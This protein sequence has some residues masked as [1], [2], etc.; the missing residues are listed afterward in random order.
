MFVCVAKCCLLLTLM[1]QESGRILSQ[2][3]FISAF[4]ATN[5]KQKLSMRSDC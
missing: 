3:N 2:Y 4:N 1:H 5:R